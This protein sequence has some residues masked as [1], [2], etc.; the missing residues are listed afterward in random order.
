MKLSERH[1]VA[2]APALS[3]DEVN[4][5]LQQVGGWEAICG[6]LE[7]N[8]ALRD[9][10]ETIAFVNALAWMI[11]QQDHHP[12]LEVNYNNVVVRFNTHSGG[13]AISENDFICAARASVIYAQRVGA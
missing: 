4:E 5:L 1:C 10:H 13:G 7:R 11:H 6:K 3:D 12:A 2:N 9:Y 8:F